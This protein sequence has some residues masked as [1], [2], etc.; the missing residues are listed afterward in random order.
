VIEPWLRLA[1]LE[2]SVGTS[3]RN[4]PIVA[5]VNRCQSPIS[6]AS[7]NAVKVETPRRHCSRVTIGDHAG[8]T[9]ISQIALSNRSRRDCAS[10]TASSVVS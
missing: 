3:P 2:D 1:P 5:P 6:T 7:P 4:A 8:S 10:S 9:A